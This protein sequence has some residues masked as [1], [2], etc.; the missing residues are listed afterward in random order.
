MARYDSHAAAATATAATATAMAVVDSPVVGPTATPLQRLP[1]PAVAVY[2][3]FLSADDCDAMVALGKAALRA[4]PPPLWTAE[5]GCPIR[6]VAAAR[7]LG[8]PLRE[9][10]AEHAALRRR[11]DVAVAA[12]LGY[13]ELRAEWDGDVV[14]K[15][16]V[17]V[18]W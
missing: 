7:V 18:L 3:G 15:G 4:S 17:V 8:G 10:S 16:N 9:L 1:A 2:E 13:V 5:A 14:G 6:T 11:L 12:V